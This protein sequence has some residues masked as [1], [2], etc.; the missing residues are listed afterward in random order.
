MVRKG[1]LVHL[2]ARHGKTQ[3]LEGFLRS[4]LPLAQG[5]PATP[6]WFA[7][8]FG[9]HDFGIFDVFPDDA[10]RDAHL[11]GPIARAL[12]SRADELLESPPRIRKLDVL[13]AKLPPSVAQK[14][15]RGILLTF[16]AK[17]GANVKVEDFLR[18]GQAVVEQEPGTL[19]WFAIHLEDGPYGVFDVFPDNGARFAHLTGRI[20]IELMKHATALLGSFPDMD[21]LEVLESKVAG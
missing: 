16:K 2:E 6:A 15:T 9:R 20:P 5:E 3:E 4:A 19:A 11:G 21:L 10:G 12:M 17:D 1:L 18:S 8:K 13:A 7:L 14:I